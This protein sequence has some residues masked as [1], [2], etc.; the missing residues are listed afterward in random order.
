M[1][2]LTLRT[3]RIIQ[4]KN[5]YKEE[6]AKIIFE[7]IEEDNNLYES[8]ARDLANII[9]YDKEHYKDVN[10]ATL[11]Q[12]AVYA[13]ILK[14]IDIDIKPINHQKGEISPALKES[15]KGE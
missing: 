4:R 2:Q 7:S 9:E 14:E 12:A 10:I 6:E 3:N 8:R 11:L 15:L 5:F 13:G 1:S